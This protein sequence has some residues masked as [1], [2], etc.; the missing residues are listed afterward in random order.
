MTKKERVLAALKRQPVDRIPRGEIGIDQR[1]IGKFVMDVDRSLSCLK[2]EIYVRDI[3]GMDYINIHEFPT[4][5][6]GYAADGFPIYKSPFGDV[7]K[8]TDNCS[9][10][11]KP[12]LEEIEEVENYQPMDLSVATTHLLDFYK[13]NTDFFL[14]CQVGGP[15]SQMAWAL[16]MEDYMCYCMTDPE[17]VAQM[18]EKMM[19]F[20]IGRAK[21]FL[22]RGADAILITD[23]IAFNTGLLLSPETMQVVA[24]PIYKK[25]IKEIKAHKDVPVILHSD[26]YLYDALPE[27][28]DCGFDAIQSIQPS[29]GMDIKKVKENYGDKLCLIGN[30]DL[31]YLLPF[32]TP[33]EVT[34]EVKKLADTVGSEGFI[35]S[36]CNILTDMVKVENAM[37]MYHFDRK[38]WNME[39]RL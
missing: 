38:T 30:V 36:T 39:D 2:R 34:V 27:I 32:G 8:Q 31:D 21:L 13:E 35:L 26:G 28:V 4:K 7:F 19:V 16:G 11:L 15:V 17:L 23:D 18:A 3:L 10:I 20:E 29:A 6:Q 37:A 1:F 24:Y 14:M 22:N 25:M 12:A 5:L 9:Q 33:E